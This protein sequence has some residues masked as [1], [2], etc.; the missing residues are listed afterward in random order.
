MVSANHASSNRSRV[1]DQA[2]IDKVYTECNLQS[3]DSRNDWTLILKSSYVFYCNQ[4]AHLLLYPWN[5][6]QKNSWEAGLLQ[7][8]NMQLETSRYFP[9]A[10][11]LFRF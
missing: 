9:E 1:D 5:K 2:K 3:Y 7:K 11:F 10:A 6:R 4:I 8:Y